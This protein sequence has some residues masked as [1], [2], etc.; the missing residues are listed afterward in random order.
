GAN[1]WDSA[2]GESSCVFRGKPGQR[3]RAGSRE[4]VESNHPDDQI[5]QDLSQ[6]RDLQI[7]DPVLCEH[8]QVGAGGTLPSEAPS[9]S[10][11]D[12]SEVLDR[13]PDVPE[14]ALKF[15]A[16]E[17][18][19][20]KGCSKGLFTQLRQRSQARGHRQRRWVEGLF[21]RR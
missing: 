15:G 17:G 16:T 11:G 14:E 1:K 4:L 9:R 21:R 7:A 2:S 13:N 3:N 19:P 12:M 5:H 18:T 6:S 10:L 8:C 20:A